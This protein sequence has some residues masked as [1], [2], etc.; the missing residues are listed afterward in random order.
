[1]TLTDLEKERQKTYWIRKIS[2]Q[3]ISCP[4][5]QL[6]DMTDYEKKKLVGLCE[7]DKQTVTIRHRELL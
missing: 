4:F 3:L 6:F 7:N 1:M 5:S 2:S